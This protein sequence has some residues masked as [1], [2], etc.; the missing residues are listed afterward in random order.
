MAATSAGFMKI[1][2]QTD[3]VKAVGMDAK[4]ISIPVAGTYADLINL[5]FQRR[6]IEPGVLFLFGSGLIGIIAVHRLKFK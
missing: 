5:T 2:Q 1:P 3:S 6:P 4:L